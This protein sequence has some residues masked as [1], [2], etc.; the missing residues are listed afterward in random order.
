MGVI[1]GV[2]DISKKTVPDP[3]TNVSATDVGTGRAYDNGAADVTYTTPTYTGRL[4]ITTHTITGSPGGGP[5]NDA[6]SPVTITGLDTSPSG[7]SHTFT[8]TATNDVGVSSASSASAAVTITSV[9]AAPTGVSASVVSTTSVDVAWTGQNTG[10]K[11]V[12][13]RVITPTPSSGVNL[14]Y[15]DTDLTS[16]IRATGT[17][18]CGTSYTFALAA[19]NANGTGASSSSG[20]ITPNPNTVPATP[21]S[22]TA[23]RTN[24]TT[25]SVDFTQSSATCATAI[26]AYTIT[27][28]PSISLSYSAADLTPP[29][30]VTGS[31]VEGTSYTFSVVAVNSVGNS[32]TGTSG[33]VTPNPFDPPAAPGNPT[34]TRINDTTVDISFTTPASDQTIT[35]Y[36]ITSNPSISLTRSDPNDLTSPI[37]VTGSF[38]EGT[39]YT[40]SITATSAAGTGSAGTTAGLTVNP[41]DPPPQPTTVTVTRTSNTV[42]S[43]AWTIGASDGALTATNIT[44]TPSVTGGLS[45]NTSDVTSPVAVTANYVAGQSYT[46]DLSFTSAYGTGTSRTSSGV[47]INTS[48]PALKRCTSAQ[49]SVACCPSTAS[50]G[51][52]GLGVSC[53]TATNDFDEGAC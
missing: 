33:S 41:F 23:T 7:T 35:S 16:P 13:S 37:R 21:T 25:V 31:F 48:A 51:T 26:T 45:Y 9:P 2:V 32:G 22:V 6:N 14:T 34:A 42:A 43:V 28:S 53:T 4:P 47:T 52:L 19:T 39:S 38:V 49:V 44:S 30:A 24:D 36:T 15:T 40:F 1:P 18:G 5:T 50:C 17:F 8:A 11:T 27:S 12:S 29:I 10:G 20:S 46:F 3:P